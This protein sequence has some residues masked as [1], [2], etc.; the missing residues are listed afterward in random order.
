MKSILI[1]LIILT[2]CGVR[3]DVHR[4]IMAPDVYE[5][6]DGSVSYFYANGDCCC[7]AEEVVE[8]VL[9]DY[10]NGKISQQQWNDKQFM[11]NYLDSTCIKIKEMEK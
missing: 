8:S 7:I 6:T 9:G 4:S 5:L 10:K 3:I 11:K 1:L 2:G